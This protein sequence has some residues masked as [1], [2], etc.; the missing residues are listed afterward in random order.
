M[1][2]RRP[3]ASAESTLR[4]AVDALRRDPRLPHR[5]SISG[6]LY[7]TARGALVHRP[8]ERRPESRAPS[9]HP[10]LSGALHRC[11][12]CERPFG[13][14]GRRPPARRRR[15]CC[16]ICRMAAHGAAR[17]GRRRTG[18][19]VRTSCQADVAQLVERRLPKP[20]VAGSNPVVRSSE[21]PVATRDLT[22]RRRS[23]RRSDHGAPASISRT[24]RA[25]R[26]RRGRRRR[27]PD[28]RAGRV[29]GPIEQV[30][31]VFEGGGRRRVARAPRHIGDGPALVDEEGRVAV[32][33]VIR[34]RATPAALQASAQVRA[35]VVEVGAPGPVRRGPR[36]PRG[37]PPWGAATPGRWRA[38]GSRRTGAAPVGLGLADHPIGDGAVHDQH[39]PHVPPPQGKGLPRGVGPA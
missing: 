26:G 18:G 8:R 13:A 21:I 5:V 1:A 29:P 35:P 39:P 30:G 22:R 20:K 34:G 9:A 15:Y 12:W 36:G 3:G 14:V 38:V 17:G 27:S 16:D 33:A 31:V 6:A 19:V 24:R 28:R 11:D 2:V 25:L 32:A 4:E 37:R 10:P 23:G 7:D